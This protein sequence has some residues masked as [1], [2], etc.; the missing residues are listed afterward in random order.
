[1]SPLSFFILPEML[2]KAVAVYPASP[3]RV[4]PES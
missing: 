1:M 2:K 4:Q 3:F